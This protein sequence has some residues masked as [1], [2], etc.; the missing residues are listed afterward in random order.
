MA[1]HHG[2]PEVVDCLINRLRYDMA[3]NRESGT[4]ILE[5]FILPS[6]GLSVPYF[7][8][9]P[10]S[11]KTSEKCG[12]T[13]NMNIKQPHQPIP[14]TLYLPHSDRSIYL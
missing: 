10:S 6:A 1:I 11:P 9:F 8:P 7:L 3:V 12:S 4:C 14:Y 2:S 5:L 13:M